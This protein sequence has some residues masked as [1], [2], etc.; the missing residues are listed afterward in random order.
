M[1]GSIRNMNRINSPL[2]VSKKKLKQ[3]SS[4]R[5][6]EPFF[7]QN[8]EILPITNNISDEEIIK[9]YNRYKI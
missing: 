6:I 2:H 3:S 5:T 1:E 8:K 4:A 9:R 7:R